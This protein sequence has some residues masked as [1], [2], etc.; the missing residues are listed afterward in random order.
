MARVTLREFG[1]KLDK[2]N[3]CVNN[4][5]WK[6][7]PLKLAEGLM[8]RR[9]FNDGKATDGSLVGSPA[10]AQAP[11]RGV[12]SQSHGRRR[13]TRGRQI[14]KKDLF[15]EGDLSRSL[16]VGTSR[17]EPVMGLS[18]ARARL[19]AEAQQNQTKKDIF[20]TSKDEARKIARSAAR[21]LQQCL[22]RNSR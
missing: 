17:G 14:G 12:Y 22:N 13:R 15:L 7:V 1:R 9:V 4:N 21:E 20:R 19:I 8:K 16:T 10:V 2:L 5:D 11:R 18:N 6:I 3:R